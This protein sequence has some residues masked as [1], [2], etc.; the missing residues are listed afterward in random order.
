ML[1]LEG[2]GIPS[3]LKHEGVKTS[4]NEGNKPEWAAPKRQAKQ[5]A[6]SLMPSA[7]CNK[8]RSTLKGTEHWAG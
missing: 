2:I 1:G 8:V 5:S 6:V 3:F 7:Q 4:W